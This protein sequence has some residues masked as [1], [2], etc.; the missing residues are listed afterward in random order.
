MGTCTDN[1]D[2]EKRTRVAAQVREATYK[3]YDVQYVTCGCSRR[4]PLRFAYRC[5]YCGEWYCQRCAER[6][7]GKTREEHNKSASGSI[8]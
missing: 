6:H 4:L 2:T 8:G 5:L 3:G 1:V 7:F